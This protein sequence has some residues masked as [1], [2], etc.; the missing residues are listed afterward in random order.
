MKDG[1][2]LSLD[3]TYRL[4]Q[5]IT[6]RKQSTYKNVLI[7]T[8]AASDIFGHTYSCTIINKL[9][10]ISEAVTACTYS[11][12]WLLHDTRS[13]SVKNIV[14]VSTFGACIERFNC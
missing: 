2:Q 10:T 3:D 13:L 5:T 14:S 4:I 7:I 8:A 12:A 6:D 1:Q 9:G 11:G